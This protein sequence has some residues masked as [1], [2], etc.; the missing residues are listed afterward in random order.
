MRS[1]TLIVLFFATLLLKRIEASRLVCAVDS[2]IFSSPHGPKSSSTAATLVL[3]L[4]SSAAQLRFLRVLGNRILTSY[5][6]QTLD[7]EA[8]VISH[9]GS[10]LESNHT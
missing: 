3:S 9:T 5:A 2:P 7:M 4:V 8:N 6:R 1:Y 10:L